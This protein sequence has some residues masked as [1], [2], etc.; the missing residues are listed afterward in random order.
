LKSRA[1]Q[2]QNTANSSAFRHLPKEKGT[3]K[4]EKNFS[5]RKLRVSSAGKKG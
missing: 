1:G 2:W 5:K 3:N 4:Q